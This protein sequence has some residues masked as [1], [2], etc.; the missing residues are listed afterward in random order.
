MTKLTEYSL[1]YETLAPEAT[2]G[3]IGG[4]WRVAPEGVVLLALH[5]KNPGDHNGHRGLCHLQRYN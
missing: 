5:L 4:G 3:V 1:L 2:E